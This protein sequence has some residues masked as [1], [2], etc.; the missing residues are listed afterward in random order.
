MVWVGDIRPDPSWPCQGHLLRGK[1]GVAIQW[2]SFFCFRRAP[3]NNWHKGPG[4]SSPIKKMCFFFCCYCESR[5]RMKMHLWSRW[6]CCF[7][8][9]LLNRS[10]STLFP[11]TKGQCK[12]KCSNRHRDEKLCF[13]GF[14]LTACQ[15]EKL[16]FCHCAS[17]LDDVFQ[18]IAKKTHFQGKPA[19]CGY[20]INIKPPQQF[21]V[22]PFA[23]CFL[24]ER[25]D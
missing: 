10:L 14:L 2:W 9:Y 15:A 4:I 1:E 6:D 8:R 19:N 20:S 22:S 21:G 7:L 18:T 16:D 24:K 5:H 12:R 3:F 25:H 11:T 13:L 23:L 17:Y